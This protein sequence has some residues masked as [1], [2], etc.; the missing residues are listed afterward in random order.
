METPILELEHIA[1]AFDG[2]EVLRGIDLRVQRGEFVTLLGAS[3]CGKTTTLR[4]IAGLEAPDSGRVLLHGQDVTEAEAD[5]RDVNTVFQSYALFPHMNVAQNIGYGLRLK[6]RSKEEIKAAVSEMLRL[7]QLEGFEKRMPDELSGGQKQRVAIARAV[8]NNPQVLLLDEPLGAL[9]LQLRRQ[10]QLELKRLQKRLGITFIY[11]THDQEEALNMSDTVCVMR[12]GVLLQAGTP[13]EVY[14]NPRTAYVAKFVGEA[15]I[16]RGTLQGV[17]NGTA[18]VQTALGAVQVRCGALQPAEGSEVC[19]A[20]RSEQ[21][22]FAKADGTNEP[23]AEVCEKS[24][25]GGMLRILLTLPDGTQITAARHGLDA[26]IQPAD[27]VRV[28][29]QPESAVLTEDDL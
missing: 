29:W 10:M 17:Q 8:V 19:L 11:I 9:D 1:K 28:F 27:K 4:I 25:A 15:N 22:Q 2:A 13:N 24:F 26:D 5:K 21:V 14:D 7:V 23:C 3:G 16:L 12:D 20:V 18:C 6:K